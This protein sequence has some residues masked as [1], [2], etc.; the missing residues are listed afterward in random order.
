MGA[1]SA[2]VEATFGLHTKVNE[3]PSGITQ[4]GTSVVQ[5]LRNN[6]DRLAYLILNL[7][8][9][10]MYVGFSNEVSSTNGILLVSAGGMFSVNVRDDFELPVKEVYAVSTGANSPIYVMEIERD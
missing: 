10:D 2:Y 7:S 1:A 6:P 4:V 3:N 9:N 8:S 5:I